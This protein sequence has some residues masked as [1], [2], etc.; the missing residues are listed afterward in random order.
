M[1]KILEDW[2]YELAEERSFNVTFELN[3]SLVITLAQ[4]VDGEIVQNQRVIPRFKDEVIKNIMIR[5]MI[6]EI[7]DEIC[8]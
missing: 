6:I 8:H 5:T 7:R 1:Y 3:G 2:A 4:Y